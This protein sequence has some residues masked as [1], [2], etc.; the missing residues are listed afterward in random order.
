MHGVTVCSSFIALHA[1]VQVSQ[2]C[3]LNR[4]F[5]PILCSCLFCQRLVDH[6]CQ[7]LF[8]GSLFCSIA[9]SVCFDTSTTLSWLWLC[10]IAW[11]LG[12][13]CLL[14]GFCFSG[15]LWQFWVF[16]CSRAKINQWDLIKLKSF[17][18]AK[19]TKKKTKRQLSEWEKI[20]SND[21]MDKG[22]ISR[23]YKQ[24]LHSTAEKPI[25]QWK[26]GQKTWID[27]SPRRIYRWPANTWKNALHRWF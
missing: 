14:L 23:I 4:L 12:E 3:L 24:L 9:L 11:V 15:L 17:C 1:A 7:G 19:E 27:I 22:L 16:C 6:R 26:N 18:T 2:Q 25:N 10:Y 8:L 5:F 13:L 21:A 20:V